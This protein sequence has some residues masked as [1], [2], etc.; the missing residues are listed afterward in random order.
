MDS[1]VK[2][3]DQMST[4]E[5]Q[6]YLETR[7]KQ[8]KERIKKERDAYESYVEETV[9]EIVNE[10]IGVSK[11]IKNYHSSATTKLNEMRDKLQE[12]GM[13][14]SNSK[15]GYRRITKDGQYQVVYKY[16]TSSDWDERAGKAENLLRDFLKD[17]IK[18]R[19]LKTYN[20]ISAL[21][22]RNKEGDLEYS[23]IQSL[24]SQENEFDDPRWKEAIRLFKE[25]YQPT[26]SKMYIE[27]YERSEESNKWKLI[28]CNLSSF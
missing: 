3:V 24:Y 27:V 11:T 18:K 8:E 1:T 6:T 10:A 16:S 13:I 9:M 23:R 2:T 15:G 14:R 25:S 20:I 28:P 12:Y 7:Q 4:E 17:T 19:D 5:L 21:L 22:E 26:T